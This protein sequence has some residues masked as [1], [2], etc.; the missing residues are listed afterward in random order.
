MEQENET[1]NWSQSVTG[2]VIRENKVLLARHTYGAGKGRLIVPGG[3]VNV[4]ES[5]QEAVMRE[6]MEETGIQVRPKEII[7]IRFNQK[8][9]YVAFLA[10]YISGDAVSDGMENSEVIW[11]DIEEALGREDVADL[12]KKLI[13]CAVSGNYLSQIP[14]DGTTK[15]G[16]YT[17]YG[18]KKCDNN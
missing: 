2:I 13:E 6:V 12:T 1:T 16:P 8:D 7:G 14:Y 10:E 15:Y 11:M 17:F 18:A 9:W 5:P 3:Y 4:G